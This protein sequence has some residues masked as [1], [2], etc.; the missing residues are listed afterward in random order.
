MM[1][2]PVHNACFHGEVIVLAILDYPVVVEAET[3]LRR[4][5]LG[6]HHRQLGE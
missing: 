3:V 1:T 4:G 5:H 2:R 6:A